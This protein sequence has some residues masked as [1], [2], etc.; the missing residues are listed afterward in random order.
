MPDGWA[1]IDRRVAVDG[2]R[3]RAR[4]LW[5][6]LVFVSCR[7]GGG[8]GE[9]RSRRGL[10]QVADA[11]VTPLPRE[12][13]TRQV[14][15]GFTGGCDSLAEEMSPANGVPCTRVSRQ[16]GPPPRGTMAPPARLP[17]PAPAHPFIGH[18]APSTAGHHKQAPGRRCLGRKPPDMFMG[19]HYL[20][21]PR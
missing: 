6:P 21:K 7:R 14:C 3:P 8:S 13:V 11:A 17:S 9:G 4:R 20:R 19:V 5:R 1:A 12:D 16:V 10:G 15:W 18:R 2:R